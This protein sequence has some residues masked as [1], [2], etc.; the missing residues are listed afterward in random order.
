MRETDLP[1]VDDR[2]LRLGRDPVYIRACLWIMIMLAGFTGLD[3]AAVELI[4]YI[5]AILLF[6]EI[7]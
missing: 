1:L 5:Y 7:S 4:C 3:A 2:I 6:L